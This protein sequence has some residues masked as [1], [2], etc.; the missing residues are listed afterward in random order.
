LT[1]AQGGDGLGENAKTERDKVELNVAISHDEQ[2]QS[3]EFRS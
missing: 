2:E 3:L 1:Q